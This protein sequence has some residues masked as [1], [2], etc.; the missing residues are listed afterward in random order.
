MADVSHS[1]V[2][3]SFDPA[4][5][6]CRISGAAC[7]FAPRDMTAC[8]DATFLARVSMPPDEFVIVL[9][10]NREPALGTLSV[11]R[12]RRPEFHHG[13]AGVHVNAVLESNGDGALL[14]ATWRMDG[15]VEFRCPASDV[16][17][18]WRAGK[19]IPI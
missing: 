15:S 9:N 4:A 18:L 17:L 8:P 14:E 13:A 6:T 7:P 19:F 12:C 11:V 2:C 16:R 3:S 1:S 5:G 10:A